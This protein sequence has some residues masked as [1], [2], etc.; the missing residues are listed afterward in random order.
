MLGTPAYM[1]P[2]H[3]ANSSHID[4]RADLWSLG[5]IAY[6]CMVGVRPFQGETLVS[7]AL[8][9]CSGKFPPAASLGEVP[10]GFDAWFAR[11]IAQDPA[12]RFPSARL[13]AEELRGLCGQLPMLWEVEAASPEQHATREK[14]ELEPVLELTRRA[15]SSRVPQPPDPRF[16][17]TEVDSVLPMLRTPAPA[18][19]SGWRWALAAALVL[20]FAGTTLATTPTLRPTSIDR[21]AALL[22]NV[23][24]SL[25]RTPPVELGATPVSAAPLTA[26]TPV[27][28]INAATA[29]PA[30][31]DIVSSFAPERDAGADAAPPGS[32]DSESVGH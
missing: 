6:E 23:A 1:S 11:A 7:L 18:K 22:R 16:P 5:V 10:D 25:R 26:A 12:Q 19:R 30:H 14:T 20:G 8:S 3:F 21:V 4:H 32:F 13:M 24:L 2:E 15:R 9:V 31:T 17:I 27:S 28:P 29:A